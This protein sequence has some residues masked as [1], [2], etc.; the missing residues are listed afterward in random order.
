MTG[1]RLPWW[2]EGPYV[3]RG[4]HGAGEPE[5][6]LVHLRRPEVE[7]RALLAPL[8]QDERVM[9]HLGG[10]CDP[11]TAHARLD[12]LYAHWERLGFGL[13]VVEDEEGRVLG[14]AGLSSEDRAGS[15]Q[16]RDVPT[17]HARAGRLTGEVQVC[18]VLYPHGWGLGYA[19]A[20]LALV[21]RQGFRSLRAEQLVALTQRS[22]RRSRRL[23]QAAGFREVGTDLRYE[24]RPVRHVLTR[25]DWSARS[26]RPAWVPRATDGDPLVAGLTGRAGTRHAGA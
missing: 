24:G 21:V 26:G 19:A 11:A 5:N 8:W 10:A 2:A 7:D 14:L 18:Y 4:P 9:L 12:A 1:G 6:P 22:D 23:L 20:A 17:E 25:S 3:A 15:S 16:D 13:S